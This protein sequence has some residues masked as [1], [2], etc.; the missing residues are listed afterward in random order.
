M[1]VA[2]NMFIR[3]SLMNQ[4]I[5]FSIESSKA[6]NGLKVIRDMRDE[7]ES[8]GFLSDEEIEAEIQAARQDMKAR[9]AANV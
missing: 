5:P 8:R 1:S 7:A 3:A 2:V 9:R 6:I 4:R